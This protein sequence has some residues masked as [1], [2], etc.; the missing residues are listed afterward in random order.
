MK[1]R[2]I[3][4]PQGVPIEELR[5]TRL[6]TEDVIELVAVKSYKAQDSFGWIG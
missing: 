5:R 1:I 2:R 4:E 6:E 3:D